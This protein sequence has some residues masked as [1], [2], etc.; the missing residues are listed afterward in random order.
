[1]LG[2]WSIAVCLACLGFDA[3]PAAVAPAVRPTDFRNWFDTAREGNLAIP[4]DVEQEARGLRYVFVAGFLNEKMPSYFAQNAQ[5]LR[6]RGV[7]RGSIHFIDPSSAKT[8][9]ENTAAVRA[10][11]LEIARAGDEPLVVIAHS[12]GACDALAFALANP[13]FIRQRVRALFLVQG[14]FGGTSVADYVAGDGPAMD[15]SIPLPFRAMGKLM[16]KAERNRL[17]RGK[18]G[19][20]SGMTRRASA[21]FWEELLAEHA[22]AIGVVGPKT[23]YVTTETSPSRLGLFKKTTAWYLTAIAGPN[24]GLVALEDQSLPELGT[25]LAVLNAGHSDLTNR[26]PSALG[27][28]RLRRAL[29]QSILMAVGQDDATDDDD[30][31]PPALEAPATSPRA[32]QRAG[33]E[34]RRT[35]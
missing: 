31:P 22:D 7:P 11:F 29:M 25:V 2:A 33:A 20:L 10:R 12:R 15:K 34:R 4:V 3:A 24:D 14:P 18:D 30:A 21:D 23:F 32:A 8:S 35:R 19:G 16:T 1:M 26:F 6:L 5:E 27:A 13:K 17:K 9:E 28:R